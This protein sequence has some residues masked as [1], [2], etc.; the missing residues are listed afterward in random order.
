MP[1]DL[2]VAGGRAACAWSA[3]ASGRDRSGRLFW[4]GDVLAKSRAPRARV[5]GSRGGG[6]CT[7]SRRARGKLVGR[8]SVARRRPTADA[9]LSHKEAPDSGQPRGPARGTSHNGGGSRYKL[10][11]RH[12]KIWRR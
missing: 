7:G 4:C 2:A 9:Q 12:S 3:R 11:I 1:L 6:R 10:T 8:S 5:V